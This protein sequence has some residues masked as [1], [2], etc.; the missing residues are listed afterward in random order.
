MT[1]A[2]DLILDD[3]PALAAADPHSMLRGVA[4]S[5]GSIRA[6]IALLDSEILDSSDASDRPRTWVLVATGATAR[7]VD[8]VVA[9]IGN[10]ATCPIVVVRGTALPGWV[11]PLDA[12]TCISVSG[13]TDEVLA[14]AALAR[15]RG[16]RLL[17]VGPAV[18]SLAEVV[19]DAALL[20]LATPA[21]SPRA[22]FWTLVATL[23]RV[24]ESLGFSTAATGS[25]EVA[26]ERLE[27][28]AAVHGPIVPLSDNRAKELGLA[29]AEA[30]PVIFGTG[31]F[32][33]VA[34]TRLAD[35]LAESA[36]L[37]SM[38]A[39]L[40]DGGYVFATVLTGPMGT[41]V[42]SDDDLF[43]D[44][45]DDGEQR[46]VRLVLIRDL[47][48]TPVESTRADLLARVAQW[49]G[50]EVDVITAVDGQPLERLASLV[51][52][53]DFAAVYSALALGIDPGVTL[54]ERHE[55]GAITWVS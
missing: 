55:D 16:C 27:L 32:G 34:A 54:N 15:R 6:A 33:A 3:A 2:D 4:A 11:G 49:R 38:A 48:E 25:V 21:D 42:S 46:R 39:S 47:D 5:G 30:L 22:R 52:V 43:R 31:S 50:I 8:A 41:P 1:L 23:L 26:A 45:M 10:A 53:V 44:R 37:A 35:Q 28:I 17:G 24:A 12:V 7:A 9:L 51:A 20:S 14:A 18:G 29:W 36:G 19:G 13:E 40:S